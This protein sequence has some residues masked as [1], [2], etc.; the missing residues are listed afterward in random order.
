[1]RSTLITAL[2]L[3]LVLAPDVASPQSPPPQE[4]ITLTQ[5]LEKAVAGN[6]DLRKD[7]VAI[8]VADAN[9]L[10]ARG[11]F[12]FLITGALNFQRSTQPPLTSQDLFGGF[13]NDLGFDVGLNRQLESGGSLRLQLQNDAIRANQRS[14]CGS[15]G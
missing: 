12:D 2:P 6:V 7:R 1:M 8:Q 3:L 13:S 5:A 11:Q 4:P 9:L 14:Q 10:A 15:I